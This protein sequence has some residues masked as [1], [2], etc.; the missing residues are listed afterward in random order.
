[1]KKCVKRALIFKFK[2]EK[3]ALVL[4]FSIY[5]LLIVKLNAVPVFDVFSSSIYH[6]IKIQTVMITSN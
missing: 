1:M 5:I 4:A 3:N 2:N 6:V